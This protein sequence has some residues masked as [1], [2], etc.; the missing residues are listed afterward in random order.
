[1]W[2]LIHKDGKTKP[3]KVPYYPSGSPRSFTHG[4][5]A[6]RAALVT[7]EEA[8]A[9]RDRGRFDGVG[10]A[11]LNDELVALDFDHCVRA[12]VVDPAVESM[13][14][15]TYCELSPSGTGVRALL[16]GKLPDRKDVHAEGDALFGF[17]TFHAKGFVTFTGRILD[18]ESLFYEPSAPLSS[19][20][21]SVLDLYEERFGLPDNEARAD[22]SLNV[23]Q[24]Q[25]AATDQTIEEIASALAALPAVYA[26]D[27]SKWKDVLLALASLKGTEYEESVTRLA[28]EFSARCP[29]KYR[30]DDVDKVWAGLSTREITPRS[31]FNW[32]Q[33]AGWINPRSAVAAVVAH[34]EDHGEED[35]SLSDVRISRMLAEHLSGRFVYQHNGRGWMAYRAGVWM[36]CGLGEQMEEGK[37]LG[38]RILQAAAKDAASLDAERAKEAMTLARRA[39]QAGG[40][41]AALKLA[42][43]DPRI[44]ANPE[45]FDTDIDLLNVANG[46]VNLPTGELR[47]HDSSLRMSRQ[48]PVDYRPDMSCPTWLRTLREI[49]N[50]DA[51]WVDYLQRVVGYVLSG[52]VSEEKLFFWIGHGSNGKSVLANV[53]RRI[54]GTYA[55]SVSANFLLVTQRDGEAATPTLATLPGARLALANEVEAGSRLSAQTVKV[56]CSTEAISARHNYGAPFV[57][58]P[59]HKLVVRANHKPIIADNDE[60]IWRR[61]DLLP[62]DRTF[63][64]HEKD[65]ELEN[66][67][68]AEAPSILAWMVRG[69]AEYKRRRLVP[70]RRV[71]AAS[72]EYRRES[73]VLGQ[74]VEE[75]ALLGVGRACRQGDAYTSY[76]L[77][78]SEQ[79][80]KSTSKKSF[81]RS[82]AERGV[83]GG[84]ETGGA[85]ERTYEGLALRGVMYAEPMSDLF[86]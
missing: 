16:R 50:D 82:L 86:A 48:C 65:V 66:K 4:S 41:T 35:H 1:V 32:A 58:V 84:Q 14:S 38:G 24:A 49:S 12:G 22:R 55:T 78:C 76:R 9:A 61:I 28:H 64:Q 15:G 42:E 27:R 13:L 2:R 47:P 33:A 20:P 44:A 79:G 54:M 67:L 7:F 45:Q 80:L 70:A 81:T 62:F 25:H 43:S 85:R 77:W 68:M 51:D 23:L 74:W 73:D 40:I 75:R 19:I 69:F 53:F 26:D 10:I 18:S 71:A 63:A 72:G 59:T 83:R 31:I 60:G 57:F 39:M 3:D 29:A 5:E 52:H 11:M 30:A 34:A 37:R 56:A 21:H 36:P 8:C 6:D 17:E 46:I